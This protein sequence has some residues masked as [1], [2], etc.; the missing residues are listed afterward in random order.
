MGSAIRDLAESI[1]PFPTEDQGVVQ[2][3]RLRDFRRRPGFKQPY[4][5]TNCYE[6]VNCSKPACRRP[7][8]DKAL[9]PKP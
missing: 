7:K 5:P 6:P 4:E 1:P 9:S 3:F 2:G 8:T